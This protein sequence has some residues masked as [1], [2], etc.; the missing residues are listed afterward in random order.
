MWIYLI[1][2]STKKFRM[3]RLKDGEGTLLNINGHK[4][5]KPTVSLL[6]PPQILH[7]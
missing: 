7:H 3:F 1:I 4:L 6:Y 5:R 2:L